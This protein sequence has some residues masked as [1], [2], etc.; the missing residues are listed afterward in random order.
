MLFL[1]G[2]WIL[3]LILCLWFFR[4][5]SNIENKRVDLFEGP[6]EGFAEENGL[7][8]SSKH[9]FHF[10]TFIHPSFILAFWLF[11]LQFEFWH[12]IC[13]LLDWSMLYFFLALI[14]WLVVLS[15]FFIVL[16]CFSAEELVS[17]YPFCSFVGWVGQLKLPLK[18][19]CFLLIGSDWDWY[20][21]LKATLH[22]SKL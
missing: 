20:T 10:C 17:R 2:F 21:N 16:T 9:I 22:D 3:D 12:K 6:G 19:Y 14:W 15:F 4:Y 5:A 11:M 18:E 13:F 1:F 8:A 7:L